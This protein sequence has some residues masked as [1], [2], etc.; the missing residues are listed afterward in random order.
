[1]CEESAT[2]SPTSIWLPQLASGILAQYRLPKRAYA[3]LQF[4]KSGSRLQSKKSKRD[5]EEDEEDDDKEGGEG[6]DGE[7][8]DGKFRINHEFSGNSCLAKENL[9]FLNL[10]HLEWLP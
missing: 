1:M 7:E 5:E 2:L 6:E 4:A 3:G 9:C 10:R 8:D